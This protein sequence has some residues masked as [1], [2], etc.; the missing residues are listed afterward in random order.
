MANQ[1]QCRN[2][3][4]VLRFTNNGMKLNLNMNT[5]KTI[6]CLGQVISSADILSSKSVEQYRKLKL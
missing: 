3:T 1:K 5:A 6:E 2:I 4:G